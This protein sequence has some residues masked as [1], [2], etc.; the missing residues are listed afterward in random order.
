MEV[1]KNRNTMNMQVSNVLKEGQQKLEVA[2]KESCAF[3]AR[4]LLS[5]VT[6]IPFREIPL[7]YMD[8]VTASQADRYDE[9]LDRRIDGEPLQYITGEQEFMGLDFHVDERVLIPRLDTEILAEE[10]LKYLGERIRSGE[11][12]FRVL[13]LCCGSGAIGLSIAKLT[14]DRRYISQMSDDA[15]AR[16]NAVQI[17]VTLSDISGQ[18]LEVARQNA[19][20]L[21]VSGKVTFIQSDL[22][23]KIEGAAFDL[24]V[25]NPPYI[26]SDVIDT[27]D[28]EVKA[29]EPR[30]ALDG[31]TDGLDVY[32]RIAEE[33]AE[34]IRQGG[35][36]MMEI[37]FDQGEDIKRLLA[38]VERYDE[39]VIK[40][41][42]AGL[43]RVAEA[44]V[45]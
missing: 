41:D 5:F 13:D 40:K 38:E 22:F 36:L 20:D 29:H 27:L 37:G 8:V 42:L 11:D 4:A 23:E 12:T 3:D 1:R 26:R 7:H 10:A 9:L 44:T 33:A 45:R 43:D 18:A 17:H 30:L 28:V 31:G 39:A 35:S 25:S 16:N 19:D 34:H 21:G 14:A 24:I 15:D 6:G 32:R 2:G